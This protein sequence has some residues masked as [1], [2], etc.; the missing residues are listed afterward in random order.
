MGIVVRKMYNVKSCQA[1]FSTDFNC[2]F[3][4]VGQGMKLTKLYLKY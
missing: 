4:G 2:Q 1:T 3:L